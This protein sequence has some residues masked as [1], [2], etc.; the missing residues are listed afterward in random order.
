[1]NEQLLY[2]RSSVTDNMITPPTLWRAFTGYGMWAV[3]FTILYTGHALGCTWMVTSSHGSP[4]VSPS[5]VT[6]VLAGIWLVFIF[7]MLAMTVRSGIRARQVRA[8]VQ[9]R[10]LRFMV[11]LTFIAD[12]SAV[13]VIVISGLP[14]V[15]TGACV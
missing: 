15:L 2:R 1:M 9:G 8:A 7:Y 4:S 6:G 13:V 3:C 11:V 14:I 10:S 12:A 5:T